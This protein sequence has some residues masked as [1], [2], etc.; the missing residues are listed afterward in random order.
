MRRV[1]TGWDSNGKSIVVEDSDV[2]PKSVSVLPASTFCH[3]WGS[4]DRVPLP[5][6]GS[7]PNWTQFFPPATGF[8]FL[9]W[10]LPPEGTPLPPDVDFNAARAELDRVLP[11]LI[12]FNEPDNPGMHTTDTVDWDYVVSGEVSLELDDGQEVRLTTGDS[13]IQNGTRHAWH[14]RTD[15]VTTIATV[16]IGAQK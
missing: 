1:V 16:L 8:R 7:E 11:G 15:E 10:T 3:L 14:N 6:D 2:E 5:S 13:V 9:V 4:D 12:E